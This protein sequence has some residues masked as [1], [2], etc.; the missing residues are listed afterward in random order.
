M[1]NKEMIRLNL[2]KHWHGYEAFLILISALE[3]MMMI[4]GIMNFDFSDIKRKMYFCSY[5]FLFF[6]SVAAIIINRISLKNPRLENVSAANVY[7]YNGVL[8]FWSAMI[9]ALDI[10]GGGY[11][12]TYMTIMAAVAS[13]N[14][15]SPIMYSC[16][17]LL[18]SAGMITIV[19]IMGSSGTFQLHTPFFLNHFIFLLV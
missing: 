4:Y 8:I 13:I 15:L 6:C 17:A 14:T 18:S 9:S 11:P 1:T 19:R 5:V 10:N 7:I 12:V 3:G 2:Q 16:M